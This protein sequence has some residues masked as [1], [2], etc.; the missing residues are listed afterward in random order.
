[1]YTQCPACLT[2]FKVTPAQLAARG[3]VV[4]CGICSSVFHAE[5]R[6]LQVTP[7]PAPQAAAAEPEDTP[8]PGAGQRRRAAKERRATSRRRRDKIKSVPPLV[9]DADFPIVTELETRARPRSRWRAVLWG[10]GNLV[11]LL[12]LSGQFVY[13]Y[14]DELARIPSWRPLVAE[15]C[16]YA[17]CELRPLQDVAAI[18]LLQTTIAPHPQYANALRI[19][20][21]LV[22]RAAFPQDYPGMEVS[23]TDNGGRVITRRTFTPAQYLPAPAAGAMS[24]NIVAATLLDVT[25][26][27]GKAVGYEIRLVT[28]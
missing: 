8:P 11:L 1:M 12:L 9:D 13:F 10:L 17:R 3:G 18:E 15:F 26:P 2:T 24:P 22:N 5:Q 4:R 20:T 19:R 25:N 14:R 27:D 23:L 21:T 6:R 7:P 16:G 28:P